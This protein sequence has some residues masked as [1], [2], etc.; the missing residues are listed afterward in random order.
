MKFETVDEKWLKNEYARLMNQSCFDEPETY[1][2]GYRNG[3]QKGRLE[4]IEFILGIV[5]DDTPSDNE[6]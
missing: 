6:R 1:T 4:M 3:Y 5:E 2:T